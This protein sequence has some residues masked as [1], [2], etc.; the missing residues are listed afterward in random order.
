MKWFLIGNPSRKEALL[1][2][3]R[4]RSKIILMLETDPHPDNFKLGIETMMWSFWGK[5]AR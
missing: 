1:E 3:R 5:V 2:R 4:H